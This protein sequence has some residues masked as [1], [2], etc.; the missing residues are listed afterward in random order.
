[1]SYKSKKVGQS[2]PVMVRDVVPSQEVL[3]ITQSFVIL[4]QIA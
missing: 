1:M 2:D 4:Q 3:A